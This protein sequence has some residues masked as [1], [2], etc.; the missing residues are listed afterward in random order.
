MNPEVVKQLEQVAETGRGVSLA[1]T[2]MCHLIGG[3]IPVSPDVA[4]KHVDELCKRV[5]AGDGA[6]TAELCDLLEKTRDTIA[7]YGRMLMEA[8]L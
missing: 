7:A 8:G 3:E 6:A 4:E 2:T 5:E 1:T